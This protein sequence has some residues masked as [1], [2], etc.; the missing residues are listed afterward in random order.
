MSAPAT[1]SASAPLQWV[2]SYRVPDE[3]EYDTWAGFKLHFHATGIR[4]Q[5]AADIL[6]ELT[7]AIE[8]AAATDDTRT[9]PDFRSLPDDRAEWHHNTKPLEAWLKAHAYRLARDWSCSE[10]AAWLENNA[11]HAREW[12][13]TAGD[14]G[15]DRYNPDTPSQSRL[16]T[17]WNEEFGPGLCAAIAELGDRLFTV[18]YE[19]DLPL[20]RERFDT[21][22][23]G[24]N[25]SQDE[26]T[27]EQSKR[28]WKQAKPIFERHL[29]L[30]R[31]D[32]AT[33]P[34]SQFWEAQAYTGMRGGL[35]IHGGAQSFIADSD[36]ER[37]HTGALQRHHLKKLDPVETRAMVQ[38]VARELVK[39]SRSEGELQSKVWAAIDITKGDPWTGEMEFEDGEPKDDWLLGYKDEDED[40][41]EYY[42]QWATIQIVGHDIPLVLDALPVHRG[43]ERRE[44]VREL[45]ETATQM[46]PKLELVM[47]DREFASDKIKT[48][49]EDEQVYYLN[50]GIKHTSVKATCSRLREAGRKVAVKRED[51]L[52][53]DGRAQV[54]I[55]ATNEE[56]FELER[57][58]DLEE[59]E[60]GP[61][62]SVEEQTIQEEL[63]AEF[64]EVV[65]V[66]PDDE[67][68]ESPFADLIDDIREVEED[69]E[70]TGSEEDAQAYA[71]FETNHPGLTREAETD[72]Q[73]LE[74][75]EGFIDRYTSRWG[76]EEGFKQIKRFQ[77]GTSSPDHKYRFFNF[78]FGCLLYN[79]W[80]LVDLLVKDALE[81]HGDG[82]APLVP[83]AVFATITKDYY[84]LDPPD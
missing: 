6:D 54:Y 32:N 84:G 56:V 26:L 79:C 46:V 70:T 47:M 8:D 42:Y 31:A 27:V 67:D 78:A 19:H 75:V 53:N 71:V 34:E 10:L 20:P 30:E 25:Q 11:A 69:E 51:T 72:E 9:P 18:C 49:C 37:P 3:P 23:V 66:N 44:I 77:V 52:F 57:A 55:P 22:D 59:E 45:L 21:A 35:A 74:Q 28:V 39:R 48:A 15:L 68:R 4:P 41:P 13:F 58:E 43:L 33:V 2:D 5:S 17:L 36:R 29:T 80:R 76:I 62:P 24:E 60:A 73:L 50:P 14:E 82:Y 64:A 38:D 83:A 65:D 1:E 12:G 61:E 63:A 16:W 7:L 81:Q 40:H